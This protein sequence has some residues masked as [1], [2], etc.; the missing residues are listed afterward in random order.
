MNSLAAVSP[1]EKG[2]KITVIFRLIPMGIAEKLLLL[3]P[4]NHSL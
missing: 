3:I 2:V 4:G 1:A